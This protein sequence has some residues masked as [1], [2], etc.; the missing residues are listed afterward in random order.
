MKHL[1]LLP[2]AVIRI[3][4]PGIYP[5]TAN[6]LAIFVGAVTAELPNITA[7]DI[8][9]DQVPARNSPFVQQ[10]C[11]DPLTAACQEHAKLL[12]CMQSLLLWHV[13][14]HA[15]GLDVHARRMGENSTGQ[16]L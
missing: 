2:Q 6:S 10:P 11:L 8:V 14:V 13:S 9:I 4:G 3:E 5:F 16:M 15:C 1:A 12:S 7:S